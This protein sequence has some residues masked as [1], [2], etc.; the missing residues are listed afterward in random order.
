[1]QLVIFVATLVLYGGQGI[2]NKSVEFST[3]F[4]LFGT[5]FGIMLFVCRT[6]LIS[7]FEGEG[8][9]IL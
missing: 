6:F 2:S 3:Y 4:T 7:K 9:I 8:W 5:Q 1:M